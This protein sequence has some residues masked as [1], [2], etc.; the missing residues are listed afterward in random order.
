M[1]RFLV[2]TGL[3]EDPERAYEYA[4]AARGLAA[5]VG[6]VRETCAIAAYQAGHWSEA[7][8]E[9]R[10]ARRLTGRDSY[11]PLMADC[12]RALGR[13]D[14]ALDIVSGPE[15]RSADRATQVELRIVESGIRRDQGLADAGVVALQIPEL[16]DK[17]GRAGRARLFY[18]YADALLDAGREEEARDWFRKAAAA[19]AAGETDAAER[20]DE[21]DE[22]LVEDLDDEEADEDLDENA[23]EE[24]TLDESAD[25]DTDADE[26]LL[27][28]GEDEADE[29]D[30]DLAGEEDFLDDEDLVELDLGAG[31]TEAGNAAG[32]AE[33]DTAGAA[34]ADSA[35]AD[36]AEAAG[37]AELDTRRAAEAEADDTLGVADAEPEAAGQAEAEAPGQAEA[38][39]PGQADAE[40]SG[41]DAAAGGDDS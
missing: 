17:R 11:L 24:D 13:L 8:A 15:A 23:D 16:T 33:I 39:A 26:G 29:D 25:D 10:A 7:L 30:D 5:R 37:A 40:A 2:A 14:R 19:D 1:A 3:Q 28:E 18:A 22:V 41:T 36:D 6:I 32:L 12:E 4:K 31:A 9:F 27:D 35:G 34:E 21:L 20:L 38:E